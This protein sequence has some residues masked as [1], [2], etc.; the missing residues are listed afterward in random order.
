MKKRGAKGQA[1][2]EFAVVVPL[3]MLLILGI[4][5]FG[6]IFNAQLVVMQSVREGA[7]RAVVVT[8]A[9]Q[10]AKETAASAQAVSAT[11]AYGNNVGIALTVGTPTFTTVSGD[12]NKKITVSA[13]YDVPLVFPAF[14]TLIGTGA[15]VRVSGTAAMRME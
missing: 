4:F 2:I 9:T 1:L 14:G 13:Y 6:R 8:G 5:E 10:A 12:T 7:R 15:N 11:Q 3:L